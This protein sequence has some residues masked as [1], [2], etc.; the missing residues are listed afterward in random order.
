VSTVT[1]AEAIAT[2]LRH[3]LERDPRVTVIGNFFGGITPHQKAF[4]ALGSEYP[5][6]VLSPPWSEL[7]NAGMG[8]GAACCGLRPVVDLVTASFVFQAYPQ[9]VNEAPNV[10]TMT[11]GN[12]TAPVVFHMLTGLRGAGAAQHSHTPQAMLWNTPGLQI[13]VPARPSDAYALMMHALLESDHPTAYFSHPLLFAE[14][15]EVESWDAIKFAPGSA[16]IAR[17]GDDV[18]VVASSV[19]VPRAKAAAEHL[20]AAHGISC[21]VV[22]LRTLAP[23]DDATV[24][25]SV[26]TTGRL[27]VAD[28][29]HRSAGVAAEVISRVVESQ[30]ERLKAAPRRVCT[31]D[32]AIPFSPPVE[33]AI[34]PS[35][36][37]I[38]G[39]VLETIG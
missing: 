10:Y 24:A 38:V 31:P 1:Y 11:G 34:T 14:T 30:F 32:V 20:A 23:F 25:D 29:C 35:S 9:V 28:E 27:V 16:R 4:N 22:D 6:R 19:M 39:A 12:T 21:E 36:N 7:G 18:T 2:A 13:S 37:D 3:A 8:V 15:E 26:A 17:Q 5:D 33:R